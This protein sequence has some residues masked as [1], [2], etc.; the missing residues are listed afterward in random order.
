MSDGPDGPNRRLWSPRSSDSSPGLS[1]PPTP[2]PPLPASSG[3]ALRRILL[4]LV[5]LVVLAVPAG[6]VA[7]TTLD[8]NSFSSLSGL[9]LNG[10]AFQNGDQ[11]RL[12]NWGGDQ[13]GTVYATTPV[14]ATDSWSA[15]YR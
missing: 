9:Q 6:A 13:A 15:R 11:I 1:V 14:D 8:Y 12:T 4:T 7:S 10:N 3:A 5:A 2:E